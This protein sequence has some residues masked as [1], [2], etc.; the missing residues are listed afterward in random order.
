[1]EASLP[2]KRR[3]P[4]RRRGPLAPKAT[5]GREGLFLSQTQAASRL[6]AVCQAAVDEKRRVYVRD[7]S[8]ACFMTLD[9]ERRCP[10]GPVVDVGL[11]FFKDNFSR[12][13]SLVKDGVCFRVIRRESSRPVYARRHDSYRD[14]L[15]WVIG[16]WRERVVAA[17]IA[18]RREEL[19]GW[20]TT[21]SAG[22]ERRADALRRDIRGFM[23]SLARMAIGSESAE[24]AE[25]SGR[26][27][28]EFD[29]NHRI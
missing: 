10:D 18:V 8:G 26:D 7:R 3:Q 6:L 4:V 9:P 28:L 27:E 15:D 14:P 25:L 21:M 2:A 16:K 20:I 1:M 29:G 23:R 12:V 19:I 24:S 5:V 17:M 11:Q 13:S 22:D